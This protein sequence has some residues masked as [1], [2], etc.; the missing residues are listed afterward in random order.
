[1]KIL[2]ENM[3]DFFMMKPLKHSCSHE[4]KYASKSIAFRIRPNEPTSS[5][6]SIKTQKESL[7]NSFN[8]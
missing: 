3:S 5:K 4:P 1:M 8:F 2:W 7:V 6:H